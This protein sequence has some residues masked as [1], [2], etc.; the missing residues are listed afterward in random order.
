M[1]NPH[2]LTVV[3]CVL[4]LS[5]C[6]RDSMSPYSDPGVPDGPNPRSELG[7]YLHRHPDARLPGADDKTF[8]TGDEGSIVSA[9]PKPAPE[10]SL[11]TPERGKER[12]TILI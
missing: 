4:C 12:R 10:R 2:L 6:G 8:S 7:L 3:V 11:E 1:K 5:G 9:V